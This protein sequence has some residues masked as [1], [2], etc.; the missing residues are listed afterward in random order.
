[1]TIGES[2]R[3]QNSP[4]ALKHN[5]WANFIPSNRCNIFLFEDDGQGAEN[6]WVNCHICRFKTDNER[7]MIIHIDDNCDCVFS[8]LTS[9]QH[10]M[11]AT[12]KVIKINLCNHRNRNLELFFKILVLCLPFNTCHMEWIIDSLNDH[13]IPFL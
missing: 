13:L 10:D 5:L 9:G 2:G 11:V 6:Y 12:K 7:Y 3:T 4:N 8:E 1:M